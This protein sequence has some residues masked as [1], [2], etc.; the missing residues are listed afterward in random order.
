[1]L[2][3][4]ALQVDERWSHFISGGQSVLNDTVQKDSQSLLCSSCFSVG[5]YKLELLASKSKSIFKMLCS[6]GLT[7]GLAGN[8]SW[9]LAEIA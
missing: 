4:V 6:H 7:P 5:T 1:M 3:A 9:N 2:Q 8:M